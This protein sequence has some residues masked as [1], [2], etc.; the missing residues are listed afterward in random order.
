[1]TAQQIAA[2]ARQVL[3]I[4]GIVMGVITAS[5]SGLHLPTA[6]S[7]ILVIA[8]SVVLAIEHYVGDPST[9]TTSLPAPVTNTTTVPAPP[10]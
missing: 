6:V 8:G 2:I 1:M 10:A 9:G 4:A 5:V 7:S 3:A